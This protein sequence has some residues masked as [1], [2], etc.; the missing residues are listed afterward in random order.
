MKKIENFKILPTHGGGVCLIGLVNGA[1]IQTSN[2]IKIAPGGRVV[3]TESGTQYLLG[4]P[5]PGI[6]GMQLQI[7]RPEK[8][9]NLQNGNCHGL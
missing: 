1:E 8:Y 2:I 7:T 4:E 3:L 5:A 6:W 9:A